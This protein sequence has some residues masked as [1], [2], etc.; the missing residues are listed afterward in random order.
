[1]LP[2]YSNSQSWQWS[3]HIGSSY[4]GFG[5]RA[6]NIFYDQNNLFLIGSYGGSLI[7][8]N[9]TLYSNG[10]NDIFIAKLDDYGNTIWLRTIGGLS[11]SPNILENGFG[12]YDTINHWLYISGSIYGTAYFGNGINLSSNPNSAEDAF[13]AKFDSSGM[14]QWA[15]LISSSGSDRSYCF[16][17]PDGNILIAGNLASNGTIDTVNISGGGFFARFN[18]DGDLLWAEKKFSGPEKFK[19]NLSFIDKDIVMAGYFDINNSTIDTSTLI[20]AGNVNGFLT[21]LDSSGHVK[22]INTFSGP[23]INGVSGLKIDATSN[24]YITG[25]FQD[26]IQL[27]ALKLYDPDNDFLLSKFD[28]NGAIVWGAQANCD[29]SIASGSDMVLDHDGNCIITGAFNGNALFGNFNLNTTNPYD[30]FIAKY[31]SSGTCLGIRNFGQASG[32]TV[33]LDNNSKPICTGVFRNTVNIGSSNFTAFL[34]QDIYLAKLDEIVGIEE[35][36]FSNNQLTI[37]ANPN[38]GNCF[39]EIPNELIND[40]NVTLSIYSSYGKLIQQQMLQTLDGKYEINIEKRA[41]GVYHVV[42]SNTTKTY[43]GKIVFE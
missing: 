33:T 30:M 35:G 31:T 23:G 20:L 36:R 27:G 17:Q 6:N 13:V 7:F 40:K 9:D 8:P 3:K 38:N 12:A 2:N 4:Q 25:T 41:K 1:M 37:F 19:L 22:W 43:S 5:E 24:I 18:N 29:G 15:K 39:I 10:H 42:L 26:S 34:G 11:L 16:V 32:F 21:R 14:C 28:E